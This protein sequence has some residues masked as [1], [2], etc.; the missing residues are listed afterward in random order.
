MSISEEE[1]NI[2]ARAHCLKITQN[3]A[4]EFLKFGI[5]PQFLSY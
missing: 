1:V 3:V 5:F 2:F 4:F